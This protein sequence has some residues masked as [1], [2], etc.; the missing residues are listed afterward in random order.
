MYVVQEL[1][2]I[3][4]SVPEIAELVGRENTNLVLGI[5]DNVKEAKM[6][7]FLRLIFT[8]FMTANKE[9]ISGLIYKMKRRLTSAD[10]VS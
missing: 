6:K 2:D 9:I 5:C 1:K 10:K 4:I 3:L 8:K 7:G